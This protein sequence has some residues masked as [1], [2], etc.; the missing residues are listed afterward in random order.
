[1][2]FMKRNTLL[3][4]GERV[5]IKPLTLENALKLI[6][7][8]APHLAHLEE[9]W[10]QIKQALEVTDGNRPQVLSAIFVGLRDKMAEV[11][12]DMVKAMGL[13]L[14]RDQAEIAVAMTAQ[15]FVSALPV[16]D[17]VNDLHGLW[18]AARGLGMVAKYRPESSGP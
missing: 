7:L 11:P 1:M 2:W 18:R 8:L 15:E 3:M 14:D 4:G 10:P 6:L 12:G 16:L 13:L 17:K 5:E 9:H